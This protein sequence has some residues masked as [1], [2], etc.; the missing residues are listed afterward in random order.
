M[1]P[2]AFKTENREEFKAAVKTKENATAL[3]E[4]KVDRLVN[5]EEEIAAKGGKDKAPTALMTE[6]RDLIDAVK[7]VDEVIG[8]LPAQVDFVDDAIVAP[9]QGVV[10]LLKSK[11]D[12]VANPLRDKMGML[13]VQVQA[14]YG[15]SVVTKSKLEKFAAAENK[16][17]HEVFR[18]VEELQYVAKNGG[19][20]TQGIP[21][22]IPTDLRN[23]TVFENV[24]NSP[25]WSK[26]RIRDISAG[27]KNTEGLCNP[28]A[29]KPAAFSL[30]APSPRFLASADD[31]R[32]SE[33]RSDWQPA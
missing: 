3:R 7:I 8:E 28:P 9:K 1:K 24:T 17:F 33:H 23:V 4:S 29:G 5:V 31:Y 15:A 6:K 2:G 25:R 30:A 13:S 22:W 18:Y 26:L 32:R 10:P 11:L 19:E 20:N 14:R 12:E 21:A 16:V 27:G